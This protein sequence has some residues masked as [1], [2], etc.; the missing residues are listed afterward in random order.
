MSNNR[1]DEDFKKSL[2]TLH[3]NGKSQ[4]QLCRDY[5]ISISA[6]TKW[7]KQYLTVE[8]P[9]GDILTANQIKEL[10]KRNA[11]LE[12]K[13]L[14]L[15]KRLPYSR[16]TPTKIKPCPSVKWPAAI[17]T[18]CRILR[19]NRSTYYKHFNTVPEART[20]ENQNICK[21]ILPI[22]PSMKSV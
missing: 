9:D 20:I 15:K 7:I 21:H 8:T 19:I 22:W 11:W 14:I 16:H 4:A 18:L 10:R 5:E 3:Q 12:K 13:N 17:K 2:V 6:L 1:Y